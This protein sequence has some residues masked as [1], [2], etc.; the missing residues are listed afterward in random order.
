VAGSGAHGAQD[1]PQGQQSPVLDDICLR[2]R[3]RADGGR[4]VESGDHRALVGRGGIY[5]ELFAL[6][7]AGY[8][9]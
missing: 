3:A 4:V 8:Q 2:L 5:A 9:P 1:D 6:Q 7:A